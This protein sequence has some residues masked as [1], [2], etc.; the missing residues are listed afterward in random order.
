MSKLMSC[1]YNMDTGCV[2]LSYS[3]GTM[4][5]IDCTTVENEITGNRFQLAEID[6]LI[7]NDPVSYVDLILNGNSRSVFFQAGEK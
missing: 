6:W 7:Y 3:D 1:E 4:I 2:E 5:F